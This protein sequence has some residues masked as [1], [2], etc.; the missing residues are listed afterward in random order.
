MQPKDIRW[1]EDARYGYAVGRVRSLETSLLDT[2][3]Y[4]RLIRAPSTAVLVEQLRATAY[5]RVLQGAA[6]LERSFDD[7]ADENMALL[8]EL[9]VESWLVRLAEL[10][11]QT[12][13]LK[14]E[15]KRRFIAGPFDWQT[16]VGNWE[17][18]LQ[19]PHAVFSLLD[20]GRPE[21]IDYLMD[22]LGQ[23]AALDM[24]RESSFF[25]RYL[26]LRADATNFLTWARTTTATSLDAAAPRPRE[27]SPYL[28]GG[29][30][31][32]AV[33]HVDAGAD[34]ESVARRTLQPWLVPV[35]AAGQRY[36]EQRGSLLHLERLLREAGLSLIRRSRYT[37]FG[38]E[39]LLAFYYLRDNEIGNLRRLAAAKAAG[40]DDETCR[41]LV[42]Y[43]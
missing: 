23:L 40:V 9:A 36:Y 25:C 33:F 41:E 10:P 19:P 32:Q 8:R 38:H 31:G 7:A 20:A 13:R 29:T 39:P 2:A 4:E 43:A 16:A 28:P 34:W 15:L 30:T 3:G 5:E 11:G 12:R 26:S 35:A 42:A 6:G 24:A 14:S 18:A 21:E 37:A 1:S 27:L 17:S 22:N